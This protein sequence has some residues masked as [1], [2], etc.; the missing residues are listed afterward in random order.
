MKK[1][2]SII[3]AVILVMTM[4]TACGGNMK[5]Y[6]GTYVGQSG[7]TLI[8]NKDSTCQYTTEILWTSVTG[9]C[10][11]TVQDNKIIITG[12]ADS[13]V[14]ANIGDSSDSLLF[15][16]DSWMWGDQLFTKTK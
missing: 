5:K 14:Y 3:I 4:L 12:L 8:L 15:R 11:W 10:S 2:I 7:S 6:A 16:S 13:D 9:D 1:I